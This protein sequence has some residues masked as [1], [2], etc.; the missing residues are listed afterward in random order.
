MTR[1][2]ADKTFEDLC[3]NTREVEHV[4]KMPF[5][6]HPATTAQLHR[7]N[8]REGLCRRSPEE[9]EVHLQ[10][11]H[12]AG[13]QGLLQSLAEQVVADRGPGRHGGHAAACV[14]LEERQAS[15]RDS[16]TR[17]HSHTH[18]EPY[19]RELASLDSKG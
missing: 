4:L 16:H 15:R 1:A 13:L 10:G 18:R 14:S 6:L 12:V 2:C 19:A 3:Y 5:S 9:G 17:T 11:G 8:N 7:V